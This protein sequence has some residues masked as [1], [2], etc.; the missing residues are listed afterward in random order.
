MSNYSS[1]SASPKQG[2]AITSLVLGVLGLPSAGCLGIGAL[3]GVI[4]GIVALV[5]ANNSPNEYGG[6]GMAIGGIATSAV[7][8]LISPAV[9]GIVAAI[10]I[11]SLLRARISANEAAAIGD[12]RTVISA[13]MAYQAS[14]G[15]SFGTPDCLKAPGSC[16][17][18]YTGP[19]FLDP[20]FILETPK[21]GYTRTFYPGPPQATGYSAFAIVAV[22]VGPQTGVRAFCGDGSGRMCST[23]SG[24]QPEVVDGS[25]VVGGACQELR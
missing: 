18:G 16:I 21:S 24:A 15:G 7:S 13:E 5:K 10:A 19:T 6:K 11:P 12:I 2:M 4:L 25:C 9:V 23:V 20:S 17:T 14:S 22:P 8:L 3:V 1:R